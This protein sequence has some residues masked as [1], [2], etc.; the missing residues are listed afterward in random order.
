ME[1]SE[2][3]KAVLG[4]LGAIV[5]GGGLVLL[6]RDWLKHRR[7]AKKQA[8]ELEL[9][10]VQLEQQR[11][12]KDR[13]NNKS[14][15]ANLIALQREALS[16]VSKEVLSLR[17]KWERAEETKLEDRRKYQEELEALE[18]RMEARCKAEME[19]LRKELTE[20]HVH[21]IA[22]LEARLVKPNSRDDTVG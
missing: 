8:A 5:G 4:T 9:Q 16:A 15:V 6:V 11:K 13:D 7:L 21:E 20:R 22:L 19:A 18:Q 17:K 3:I 12:D 1:W 10:K 2:I 14:D